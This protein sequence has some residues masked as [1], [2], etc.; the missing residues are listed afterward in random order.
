MIYM[1]NAATTRLSARAFEAMR[2]YMMEQYANAAGTYSFA[3]ASS[4][5]IA[6]ASKRRTAFVQ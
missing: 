2:P 1:D 5:A 3:A 4:A 6:S